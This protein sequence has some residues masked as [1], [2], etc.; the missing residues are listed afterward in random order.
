M[1][2]YARSVATTLRLLTKYGQQVTLRQFTSG[3]GGYD[4]LTGTAATVSAAYVDTIRQAL[5]TDAPG[6]RVGPQYGQTVEYNTLIQDS[7]KWIYMDASGTAPRLQDHLIVQ[8]VE[9]VVIDVQVIS[10]GAVPVLYL[11][12]LRA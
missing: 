9:Y 5:A 4:P 3:G 8:G 6:K 7:D 12:V 10:P 2:F 11:L 1:S